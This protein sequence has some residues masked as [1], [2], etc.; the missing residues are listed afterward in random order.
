MTLTSLA[1]STSY[2]LFNIAFSRFFFHLIEVCSIHGT[3]IIK[4]FEILCESVQVKL[5]NEIWQNLCYFLDFSRFALCKFTSP[6]SF[7]FHQASEWSE[8]KSLDH[9]FC[10]ANVQQ[11]VRFYTKFSLENTN[12]IYWYPLYTLPADYV[13]HMTLNYKFENILD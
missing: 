2:E 5:V 6:F 1:F 11:T 10:C 9:C 7:L 8:M 12:A 3:H 13:L 4:I